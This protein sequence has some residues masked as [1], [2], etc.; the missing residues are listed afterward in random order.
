[1]AS[2]AT[3]TPVVA[4]EANTKENSL[5]E[6][7]IHGNRGLC[8]SESFVLKGAQ[9]IL[10]YMKSEKYLA[11]MKPSKKPDLLAADVEPK[12]I[13]VRFSIW[14]TLK[15]RNRF[16]PVRINDLPHSINAPGVQKKVCLIVPNIEGKTDAEV[17]SFYKTIA[18]KVNQNFS[19][20]AVTFK[21]AQKLLE[22][23][24]DKRGFAKSYDLFLADTSLK[25]HVLPKFG[26]VF[27]RSNR[28]PLLVNLS[29]PTELKS[30]LNGTHFF[31]RTDSS[32]FS[33]AIGHTAMTA[34]QICENVIESLNQLAK[35]LENGWRNVKT[36][37]LSGF[38]TAFI[39][40]Y[41]SID[42]TT[43]N[44]LKEMYSGFSEKKPSTNDTETQTKTLCQPAFKVVK[45]KHKSSKISELKLKMGV[46]AEKQKIFQTKERRTKAKNDTTDGGS[47]LNAK[48]NVPLRQT[49]TGKPEGRKIKKAKKKNKGLESCGKSPSSEGEVKGKDGKAEIN[50]DDV[51]KL[52]DKEN[53]K[54]KKKNK[55]EKAAKQI[56]EKLLLPI[57]DADNL[58]Q[59]LEESSAGDRIDE[60]KK[61]KKKHKLKA[62]AAEQIEVEKPL[63]T[64]QDVTGVPETIVEG[65]S[66]KDYEK[67]SKKKNKKNK[68]KE[69]AANE[70]QNMGHQS[71]SKEAINPHKQPFKDV[72]IK[73]TP[74]ESSIKDTTE[75]TV[76]IDE[77]NCTL[78]EEQTQKINQGQS[79]SSTI[80]A[81]EIKPDL[82]K[83]GAPLIRSSSDVAMKKREKRKL[84]RQLRESATDSDNVHLTDYEKNLMSEPPTKKQKNDEN[85]P[86]L[87]A[88]EKSIFDGPTNKKAKIEPVS[89]KFTGL[90]KHIMNTVERQENGQSK[91]K[92][93]N[94]KG[95]KLQESLTGLEKFV[96]EGENKQKKEKVNND[97]DVEIPE[98]F[99]EHEKVENADVK[100]DETVDKVSEPVVVQTPAKPTGGAKR[101]R[102]SAIGAI[103]ND[104]TPVRRSKRINPSVA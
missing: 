11:E 42:E 32:N 76:I 45:S 63:L 68:L 98:G 47:S 9:V 2:D 66:G 60:N 48:E 55:K 85:S 36:V 80:S 91:K 102:S 53:K 89:P 43:V 101:T 14:N 8:L 19:Y 20:E 17:S 71:I 49:G 67:K 21:Q 99:F 13:E 24:Q 27:Q 74:E 92:K 26:V 77:P 84:K 54:A 93:R 31:M 18:E 83:T 12:R 81:N 96:F 51:N 64:G 6:E 104:Q 25:A 4:K 39:P 23:F 44:D 52:R 35:Q 79:Q 16:F 72:E 1:M 86:K 29:R 70:S 56:A 62:K 90:E 94:R 37:G 69:L 57:R 38:M 95:K 97:V 58:P 61:A 28:F 59:K 7:E 33:Y 15:K 78:Q 41:E 34:E 22:T 30:I 75:K 87:T 50:N 73:I 88:R 46:A 100:T 103:V 40:I 65:S 82:N 3:T 10:A 5:M